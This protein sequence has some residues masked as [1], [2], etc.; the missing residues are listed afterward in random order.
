MQ[1]K[2][3]PD[4]FV[5]VLA[6]FV[7]WAGEV[8]VFPT[9]LRLARLKHIPKEDRGHSEGLSME[10]VLTKLVE[11][12][13][14][15][16]LFPAFGGSSP[17]VAEEQVANRRGVSA[18]MIACV[19]AMA[20]EGSGNQQLLILIADVKGAYPNLWRD[21]AWAKLANAHDNLA[22]VK[23]L[24]ALNA[25]VAVKMV[26]HDFES[27]EVEL[28]MG[29]PQGA[30]RSGDIFGTFNSDLP[31]ELKTAGAGV[32]IKEEHITCVTFLD[33]TLIPA[34]HVD[35]IHGSLRTL[36]EYGKR[37]AQVWAKE[38]FTVLAFNAKKCPPQWN[39]D[40]G[41]IDTVTSSKYLGVTF[42]A[43]R[44]WTPHFAEKRGIALYVA[45]ELRSTGLIGGRNAPKDA[46][47]TVRAMVWSVL[48]YGRAAANL[49]GPKHKGT[50]AVLEGFQINLLRELLGVSKWAMKDGVLGETGDLPDIWRE[51][52]RQLLVARQ[53]LRAPEGSLPKRIA[54]AVQKGTPSS[55]SSDWPRKF[56]RNTRDEA[57]FWVTPQRAAS[58]LGC[59][60]W[61]PKNGSSGRR[62][63]PGL[64]LLT[65]MSPPS[66]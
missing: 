43:T 59:S 21:A 50:K 49:R 61:P 27:D 9:N 17:P 63:A 19:L 54:R 20:I 13:V 23:R 35:V 29:A 58:N 25:R 11:Q 48:D 7:A 16:P 32:K 56:C 2:L 39:F 40:N 57:Q 46:L 12:C 34:R 6:F 47:D 10:S 3:A 1:I 53:M 15:H 62:R 51:R 41:W 24:K 42:H 14:A 31:E 30:P 64:A 66:V 8:C 4:S 65:R 38:K 28:K 60:K 5:K 52:K 36:D 33:D 26:E 55:G 45:H 37:W 44:G 22:D 18:E